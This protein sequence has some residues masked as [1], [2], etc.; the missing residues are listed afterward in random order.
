MIPMSVFN[1][2]EEYY[3]YEADAEDWARHHAIYR[4]SSFNEWMPLSLQGEIQRYNKSNFSYWIVKDNKRIGGALIKSNTIKCIFTIPPFDNYEELIKALV[5][6]VKS[7]SDGGQEIIVP[8]ANLSM[9]EAYEHSGFKLSRIEKLMVCATNKYPVYWDEKYK[10]VIPEK[11]H[12]ED[13]AKLYYETYSRSKVEY[14]AS[15]TYDFQLNSVDIYFKHKEDLKVPD[16]WSALVY[17]K[18]SNKLIAACTVGL[19]NELPYILDMVV[20]YGYQR[21]GIAS[22]LIKRVLN[23]TH[24]NYPALRLNVTVGNDAEEFYKKLGFTSLAEKG[25][26]I[27]VP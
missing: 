5:D 17:D 10:V 16:Y 18:S 15:Q 12:F 21:K 19:V 24:N 14:I 13:M 20:D 7:R 22:N 4:L 27:K 23:L 26:M 2:S 11:Q 8:D 3:I 1:I 25:L 6:Y 9:R